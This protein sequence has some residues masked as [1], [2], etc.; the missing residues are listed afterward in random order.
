MNVE[1]YA[2]NTDLE[3]SKSQDNAL[4]NSVGDKNKI[5]MLAVELYV[6]VSALSIANH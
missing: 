3:K 2:C 6:L 1:P 4:W 5:C